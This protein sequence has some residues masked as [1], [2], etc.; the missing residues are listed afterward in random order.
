[1]TATTTDNSLKDLVPPV[2]KKPNVLSFQSIQNPSPTETFLY[3]WEL[4]TP[5][6]EILDESAFFFETKEFAMEN[7]VEIFGTGLALGHH[8]LESSEDE[9]LLREILSK[10]LEG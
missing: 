7:C 5:A 8:V 3:Y 9:A 4:K 2:P 10:A 1:M 6:D